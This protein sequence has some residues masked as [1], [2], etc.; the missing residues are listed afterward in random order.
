MISVRLPEELENKLK[1][2]SEQVKISKSDIVKNALTIYFEKHLDKR[3][4]YELGKDL[5]GRY[6]SGKSNLSTDY[7][8][9]LKDKLNEK[10]SR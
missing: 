3:T 2:L 5:F 4:P 10:H 1:K 9:I 7:K 6:G 8:K